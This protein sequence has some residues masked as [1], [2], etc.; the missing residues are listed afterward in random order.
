MECLF[1]P[2]RGNECDFVLL[3]LRIRGGSIGWR[4][5]PYYYLT[6]F[7]RLELF[8]PSPGKVRNLFCSPMRAPR[9]S[10][11]SLDS[12]SFVT[13][14]GLLPQCARQ[15]R[16]LPTRKNLI[17]RRATLK[18]VLATKP[19]ER[20]TNLPVCTACKRLYRGAIHGKRK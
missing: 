2:S 18:S 3:S 17:A 1:A 14:A 11:F 10:F 6:R 4:Q 7:S 20:G 8:S 12:T 19:R 13:G 15:V 16:T 5:C 9:I